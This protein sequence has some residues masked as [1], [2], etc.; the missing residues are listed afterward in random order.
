MVGRKNEI[1][2][3]CDDGLI[4][5]NMKIEKM[6]AEELAH[7]SLRYRFDESDFGNTIIA[8]S[9]KGI[10]YIAFFDDKALILEDLKK[11]FPQAVLREESDEM[12]KRA[13]CFIQNENDEMPEII[14]HLNGT[15][16]QL[17][18]WQALLQIPAGHLSTYG[19]LSRFIGRPKASRAVGTAVGN[20][21][22]SYLIPCHRVIRMSGELGGY[23]WGTNRKS[24][25][26]RREVKKMLIINY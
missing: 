13:L 26:I 19:D 7:L 3:V 2:G 23:R 15:D 12:Q 22:V 20:N 14:L 25:M 17:Q 6:T 8:T 24:A 11:R 5:F 21:P 1:G 16:F 18:V 4:V 9:G 10:C